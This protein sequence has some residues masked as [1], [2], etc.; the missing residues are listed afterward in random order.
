MIQLHQVSFSYGDLSVLEKVSFRV[1]RGEFVFLLGPSGSGKT[2][3]LR[4]LYADLEPIGGD[5]SVVGQPLAQLDKVSLPYFRQKI[6]IVF[7][8]LKFL[9]DKT[10]Q[11]NLA[12][13]QRLVGTPPQT[14]KENVH[15][16]LNQMGLLHHQNALP[17][18]ISGNE[19][20]RLA[21]ARAVINNPLL[22]LA[23]APTEGLDLR[24]SLEVMALLD[25]LNFQGMTIFVATSDRQLAE[26]CNKRIIE[27]RDGGIH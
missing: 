12:L 17:A 2:T 1:E 26:K 9:A 3:L 15:K 7:Q 6:G 19:R 27:L 14:I 24:L 21:I 22:L 16:L 8:D 4:L 13:P 5:L 10:V 18:E 23:D 11:D 20:R 25:A